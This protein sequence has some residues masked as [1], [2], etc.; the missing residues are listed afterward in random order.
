MEPLP[1]RDIHLPAPISGWPPAIGWWLVLALLILLSVGVVR[2]V[3]RARR[4]T[5]ARL[6]L[7]ALDELQQSSE[8]DAPEKARQLSILMRR[9]AL[10]L[11]DRRQVASLTGEAWLCWLDEMMGENEARFRQGPGKLLIEAPYRALSTGQELDG[12][13]ELCREWLTVAGQK[14]ATVRFPLRNPRQPSPT[15]PSPRNSP[16]TP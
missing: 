16:P 10:T 15:V 9:A 14:P 2:A 4:M 8:Q 5:P 1:L 3:Y 12:L 11:R 7:R 13:F 6:A